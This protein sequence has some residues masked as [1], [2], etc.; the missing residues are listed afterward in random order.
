MCIGHELDHDAAM[1]QLEACLLTPAEMA[2]GQ[3]R[4]LAL[5]DPYAEPHAQKKLEGDLRLA[6]GVLV[7][8]LIIFAAVVYACLPLVFGET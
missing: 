3:R 7:T 2:A 1:A 6:D 5:T 8:L 4:W